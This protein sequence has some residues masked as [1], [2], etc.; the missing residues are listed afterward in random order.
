MVSF[1]FKYLYC[2]VLALT[3]EHDEKMK[4]VID[5]VTLVVE[6][7]LKE[8]KMEH[9]LQLKKLEKLSKGN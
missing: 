7:K 5:K 1:F 6:E 3:K 2:L 4:E 8:Q 9:E